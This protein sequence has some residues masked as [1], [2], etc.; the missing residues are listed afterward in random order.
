MRIFLLSTQFEN[1]LSVVNVTDN[2]HQFWKST[3]FIIYSV[4]KSTQ[5]DNEVCCGLMLMVWYSA[6]LM[7][8]L[9]FFVKVTSINGILAVCGYHDFSWYSAVY[10]PQFF[11]LICP[12]TFLYASL[13]AVNRFL[14]IQLTPAAVEYARWSKFGVTNTWLSCCCTF[15][16]KYR[17]FSEEIWITAASNAMPFSIKNTSTTSS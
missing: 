5:F 10:Y 12:A 11:S 17:C 13:Y 2:D 14:L 16:N 1:L 15:V 6:M 8:E 4:W 7:V 9:I 3:Q